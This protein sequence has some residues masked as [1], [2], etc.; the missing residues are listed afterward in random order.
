[1]KEMDKEFYWNRSWNNYNQNKMVDSEDEYDGDK[2]REILKVILYN[3]YQG[4]HGEIPMDER[5]DKFINN[6]K[7]KKGFSLNLDNFTPYTL[8][9]LEFL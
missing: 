6:I 1:V 7:S 8:Q 3:E 4:K 2:D 5:I 9:F